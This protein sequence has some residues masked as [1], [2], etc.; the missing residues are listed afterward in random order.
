MFLSR[1]FRSRRPSTRSFLPD[2]DRLEDRTV[3]SGLHTILPPPGPAA[4]IV[5]V[6]PESTPANQSFNVLVKVEDVSGHLATGYTGSVSLALSPV[7]TGASVPGAYTFTAADHGQHRFQVTLSTTGTE[8]I[9]ATGTTATGTLTGS[10]VTNVTPPAVAARVLVK[11]PEQAAAGVPTPVRV[12]IVDQS[13]HR[14]FNYTG[15]V[16][17]SSTDTTATGTAHRHTTAASLP[18]SYTFSAHDHGEHTFLVTFNETPP[19]TGTL[20]TVTALATNGTNPALTANASLTVFPATTVTHLGLFS[21]SHAVTG[22]PTAVYVVALNASD[23]VVKG[24]T[25]QVSFTSSD[26]TATVS[27]TLGGTGTSLANFTY[28]FTSADA[29]VHTFWFTFDAS[30]KQT[31]TITDTAN[32]LS[33][34]TNVNV[35]APGDQHHHGWWPWDW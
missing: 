25:G 30:G 19:A 18:I 3:P 27:A 22:S 15:T 6:V 13:G 33:S 9:T 26:T 8:T 28:T 31:V 14:L 20:T 10:A 32:N 7:D 16:T 11:V 35:H 2:L 1:W 17:I 5:V 29:G 12:E 21:F 24:Y 23:Q 34:T 4:Q